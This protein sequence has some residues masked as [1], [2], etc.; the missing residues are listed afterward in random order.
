VAGPGALDFLQR[1]C[2]NQIDRPPGSIAYTAMLDDGGGIRCDLTVTRL[3]AERFLVLTGGATG[4]RDLAWMR[5]HRPADGSVRID[6]VTS[7]RCCVGVW[8]PLARELVQRVSDDDLSNAACPYFTA[9]SVTIGWVPALALR[10][11]YVGELGWEIYA[12]TEYGRQL[13]DTL[14]AA[15]QSLGAVAAGGGAFDSLRLEKGYRLWGQDIHSEY[16]PYEAG[17]GFAVALGKGDFV[18]RSALERVKAGPRR[19]LSC[20]TFDDPAVVVMGKEP[21]LDGA[22]VLGYVTSANYG[23]SVGQSI[24]YGY[25]PIEH[26][27][28]GVKVEVQFFGQRHGATV[29]REPLYDPGNQRLRS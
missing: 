2:A 22:R 11:S 3:D 20:L 6:D 8:G 29:A 27:A 13:W 23:Y 28:P 24:A 12:P 5:R 16:N 21:I 4:P 10:L 17:L 7:G 9:R 1:L 25:L 15:G 18:G 26:A 19:R 14:W